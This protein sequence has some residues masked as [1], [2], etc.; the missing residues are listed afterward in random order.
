MPKQ[1]TQQWMGNMISETVLQGLN[2]E[3]TVSDY[4]ARLA[5][6]FGD[7]DL[8]TPSSDLNAPSMGALPQRR[9]A[10]PRLATYALHI[11]V[12]P[13]GLA[14]PMQP[15]GPAGSFIRCTS[16]FGPAGSFIRCTSIFGP[17]GSPIRCTLIFGPEGSPI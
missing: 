14:H 2:E 13:G 4:A 9:V 17:D 11:N 1:T 10:W 5:H 7:Q 16:I 3:F 15:F 8:D 12:G 6:A